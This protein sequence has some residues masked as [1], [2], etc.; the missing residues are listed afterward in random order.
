MTEQSEVRQIEAGSI[1]TLKEVA[2]ML[3]M[4]YGFIYGSM[5][6]GEFESFRFGNQHRVKGQALLDWVKR[7]E[8]EAAK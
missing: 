3:K 1:Y 5:R 2:D 6:G 4:S 7:L 8:G